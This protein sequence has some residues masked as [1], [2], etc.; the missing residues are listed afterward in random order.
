MFLR[1]Q[2][3]G[4]GNLL[5]IKSSIREGLNLFANSD[6]L[7]VIYGWVLKKEG[8]RKAIEAFQ[9]ALEINKNNIDAQRELRLHQMRGK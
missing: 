7:W 1:L 2:N 3:T 4:E 8:S 5:E 6:T 9:E